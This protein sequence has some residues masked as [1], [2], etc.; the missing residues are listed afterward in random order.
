[1]RAR[2][3]LVWLRALAPVAAL[4]WAAW[5][6]WNVWPT[7]YQVLSREDPFYVFRYDRFG[8]T[9]E[10]WNRADARWETYRGVRQP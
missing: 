10:R 2:A 3:A 7:R 4:A 8:G 1:V 5:F 9:V 6:T